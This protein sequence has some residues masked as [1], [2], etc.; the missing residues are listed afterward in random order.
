[1]LLI[2]GGLLLAAC[3]SDSASGSRPNVSGSTNPESK[4]SQS[5]NESGSRL[6]DAA[7]S[8]HSQGLIGTAVSKTK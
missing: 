5:L 4:S 3:N 1:M 6:I 2:A 7:N 8:A